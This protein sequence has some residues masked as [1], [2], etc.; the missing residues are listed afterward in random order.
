MAPHFWHLCR[1]VY[2]V[3][4][5]IVVIGFTATHF[6]Q[7]ASI[8]WLWLGLSLLGLGY[9]I[10]ETQQ[11][12][13]QQP[14]CAHLLYVALVWT[15]T[16]AL[17]MVVSVLPFIGRSIF[18]ALIPY[19]GIFWLFQMGTGHWLNGVVNPPRRQFYLASG[20]HY[21]AGTLCLVLP[22]LQEFQYLLAGGVSAV[23]MLLL[24]AV[25]RTL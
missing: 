11:P 2:A 4:A 7:V 9:M 6:F 18:T 23:A 14:G 24:I 16:I 15:L 25:R 17:G 12:S 19:L 22:E 1:R 8:N 3:W 13:F 20:L 5:A 10:Y 21:A